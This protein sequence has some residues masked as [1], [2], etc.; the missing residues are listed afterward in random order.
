MSRRTAK[1]DIMHIGYPRELILNNRSKITIDSTKESI[2][3]YYIVNLQYRVRVKK[4]YQIGYEY[5]WHTACSYGI[6]KRHDM[7]GFTDLVD[8]A[9]DL[10]MSYRQRKIDCMKER[11]YNLETTTAY[12]K[13]KGL[14]EEAK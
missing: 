13:E 5:K 11:L 3:N 1:E 4:W 8:N 6:D 12:Y 14:Q 7:S 9:L 10:C 2:W